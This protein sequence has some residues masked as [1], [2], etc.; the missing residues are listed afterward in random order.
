M[1]KLLI[2]L[3]L[4]L[5]PLQAFA[6][7]NDAIKEAFPAED[8]KQDLL[9]AL[10]EAD[11]TSIREAI[12]LGLITCRELTEYYLERIE[13]YEAT[14]HC[15]ITIC[16]N[17]LE[18]ADKRDAAIANGTAAGAL[19][20]VPIVVKDN[21]DYTGY[22]TTNGYSYYY[23]APS[24]NAA[25]VQNLLD[26]G[27]IILGK[28]NMS[29]GAQDAICSVSD[30]G[31]ET[32]NAYNP[33]LASGGSSGGSAAAVSLNLCVA[34]LG[35]D[36]NVSLRYPSALNGCVSMRPTVGLLD[37]EGCVILN[38]SR[39]TPG[40]ITR[41]VN[42]QAIMLDVMTGGETNY[43]EKLDANALE[44]MR[45]GVLWELSY[46]ISGSY[47]RAESELDEEI[48]IAFDDAVSEFI[49]CG[50]EVVIISM[51]DVFHYSASDSGSTYLREQLNAELESIFEENELSA[52]LFP[53]YLHTPNYNVTEHPT[54]T[55]GY[56]YIC[57]CAKLSPIAGVPEI[58]IPIG[59]H[60]CGAGIG[61]EILSLRNSEQLLLNIAYSYTSKYDHR[62]APETAPS[63]YASGQALTL[64]EYIAQYHLKQTQAQELQV[65]ATEDFDSVPLSND[66]E[67]ENQGATEFDVFSIPAS[68]EPKTG[69]TL[70][71]WIIPPLLA[72]G[73]LTAF[74]LHRRRE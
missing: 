64:S 56:A 72:I 71:L 45:I 19:F 40:T 23:S 15:F 8:P 2:L 70:Y 12:D 41:N 53:S 68:T 16:D 58:T 48:L 44:G 37:R 30:L 29:A 6:A 10:Y 36:T 38:Y 47:D 59:T 32:F 9:D 61:M 55:G 22:P 50:A 63:L 13:A 57:N 33:E 18:E 25:V 17:A 43:A 39:D 51:P 27:A 74:R 54:P 7:D 24:E 69:G 42:D 4:L 14:F 5:L 21:I 34:G 65:M 52:L 66:T 11:I 20:G 60:S 46:P 62:Q 1:K 3:C 28:T 67:V 31:I 49:A 35:T 26:E 73:L